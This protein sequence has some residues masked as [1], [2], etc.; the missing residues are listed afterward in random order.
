VTARRAVATTA[1]EAPWRLRSIAPVVHHFEI[2]NRFWTV[3]VLRMGLKTHLKGKK[4]DLAQL[5]KA[6]VDAATKTQQRIGKKAKRNGLAQEA[7]LM[8]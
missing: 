8:L 1:G 2:G 6:I 5:G 7:A 4:L 3:P